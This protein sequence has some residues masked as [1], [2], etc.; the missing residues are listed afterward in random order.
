LTASETAAQGAETAKRWHAM[1]E[2]TPN[3][4]A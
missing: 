4:V 3:R 2:V 1:F